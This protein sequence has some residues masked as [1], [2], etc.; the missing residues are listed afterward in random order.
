MIPENSPLLAALSPYEQSDVLTNSNVT[1][2]FLGAGFEVDAADVSGAL[3]TSLAW[4]EIQRDYVRDLFSYIST[5]VNLTF[6]ERPLGGNVNIE[7]VQIASFTDTT[8]GISI[9]QAP[10]VSKIVVPTEFVD[11]DDVTLIHEIGHS[12]GLSHPFDGP[13]KLPGVDTDFDLGQFGLNTE[14]ATRMSYIPGAH[15]DHPGLEITGEPSAFGALDIAALQ[16]LYGANT[17][18]GTGDTFYG[19]TAVLNTIWDNNGV[20]SIDFSAATDNAVIDLRAATLETEANGGGY[21]TFIGR[22]NGTVAH[23]GYTIAFGVAIE[24]A[25]GGS[26][27]DRLTG[28]QLANALTGGKGNDV[29]DGGDSVDTANYS[30]NQRSY[31]L[32]VSADGTTITDRR[33]DQNGTD[34]LMNME[35]LSFDTGI[36]GNLFDLSIFGGSAGLAGAAMSSIIELYIAYFNRAPDAVG[37][38]YWGT[39][40]SKGFTLPEMA[41]SFFVQ[42]ETRETYEA[43]LDIEGNLTDIPAF[44]TSVYDNVLGR[45]ADQEGFEY[46]VGELQSNPDIT[47]GNFILAILNGAKNPSVPTAQTAVDQQYLENKI[48]VGAYYAVTKGM[49]D[50]D[51]VAKAVMELYEGTPDSITKTVE[52][53]NDYHTAAQDAEGGAFLMPLVGVL[54]DPFA[55]G[56]G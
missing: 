28:N 45:T 32:T 23:G 40:F 55:S 19:E 27:D 30:G 51:V 6:E 20:D 37:L 44:V 46:W 56:F 52:A 54:D 16:L 7:F 2:T 31:T 5:V 1:Y 14:L 41:A 15:V 21:L 25:V 36:D 26:G 17:S 12:L 4:S 48:D 10:G 18:T 43:V 47:P 9:P 22:E 39:E 49:T 42:R 33:A 13:A 3:S 8:T 24:N 50:A 29:I 35:F 38:N 34:T 53:I 11:L